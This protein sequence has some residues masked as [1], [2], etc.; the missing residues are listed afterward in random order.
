MSIESCYWS[1]SHISSTRIQVL[2][3]P[4]TPRSYLKKATRYPNP[5]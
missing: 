1:K 2:G 4:T 3:D 5:H